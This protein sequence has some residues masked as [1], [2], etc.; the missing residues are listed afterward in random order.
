MEKLSGLA[1]DS[2]SMIRG[3]LCGMTEAGEWKESWPPTLSLVAT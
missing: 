1:D 3:V 2:S